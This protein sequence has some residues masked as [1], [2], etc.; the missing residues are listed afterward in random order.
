VTVKGKAAKK[1]GSKREEAWVAFLVTYDPERAD[2]PY[3]QDVM[4][5]AL[6]HFADETY[7]VEAV[8][9][10]LVPGGTFEG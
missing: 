4:K 3:L 2:V 8:R 9:G 6:D 10:P 7:E 5:F 1:P